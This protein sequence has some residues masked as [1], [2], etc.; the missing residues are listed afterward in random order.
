MPEPMVIGYSTDGASLEHPTLHHAQ[1]TGAAWL[2][3]HFTD[4]TRE[5]IPNKFRSPELRLWF[6]DPN[7]PNPDV[8]PPTPEDKLA[9]LTNPTNP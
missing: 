3:R 5:V 1:S 6:M 2:Y 9:W 8:T 7:T 4:N